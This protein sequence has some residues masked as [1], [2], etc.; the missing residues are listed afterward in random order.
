VSVTLQRADRTCRLVEWKPWPFDNPSLIGHASVAFAGGWVVHAIPVFRT[1]DG[2]SVGVPSIAQLDR[3]GCIKLGADGKR[4]YTAALSFETREA[5]ERWQR[6][7][8][9]ALAAAGIGGEP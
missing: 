2:I 3:D 7:V 8:L 9:G 1:K 5:R 6:L 4:A